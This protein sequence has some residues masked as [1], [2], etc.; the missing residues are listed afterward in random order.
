MQ[1]HLALDRFAIANS[2]LTSGCSVSA[3]LY[4]TRLTQRDTLTHGTRSIDELWRIDRHESADVYTIVS[5]VWSEGA[6]AITE[7][8]GLHLFLTFCIKGIVRIGRWCMCLS[9]YLRVYVIVTLCVDIFD[10]VGSWFCSQ[11]HFHSHL[12]VVAATPK[13]STILGSH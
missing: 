7:Y 1:Q 10:C 8:L 5:E 3:R 4:E 13:A 11:Y 12:W 9:A 2:L 6:I